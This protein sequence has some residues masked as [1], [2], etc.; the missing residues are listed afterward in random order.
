MSFDDYFTERDKTTGLT[1]ADQRKCDLNAMAYGKWLIENCII[2]REGF[3][4]GT[5]NWSEVISNERAYELYLES[6]KSKI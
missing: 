5:S 4:I 2:A 1:Q 6:L 3:R